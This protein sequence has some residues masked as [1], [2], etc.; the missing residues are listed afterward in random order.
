MAIMA[1]PI[2]RTKRPTPPTSI[3]SSSELKMKMNGKRPVR[4]SYQKPC[5][6]VLIGSAPDIAAAA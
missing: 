1:Q 3:S 4:I 5:M 2:T 6:P